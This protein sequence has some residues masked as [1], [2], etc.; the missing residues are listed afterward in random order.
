MTLTDKAPCS[1]PSFIIDLGE[2]SRIRMN[3]GFSRQISTCNHDHLFA[4]VAFL[5]DQRRGRPLC[6]VGPPFSSSFEVE[7]GRPPTIAKLS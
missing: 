6:A 1:P 7:S 2:E 5:P 4:T 3:F